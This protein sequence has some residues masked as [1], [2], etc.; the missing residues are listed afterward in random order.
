MSEESTVMLS[1]L[2]HSLFCP[3]QRVI[4]RVGETPPP[5]LTKGCRACSLFDQ[6]RPEDVGGIGSVQHWINNQLEAVES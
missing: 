1:A 6:C 5:I 3:W 4:I 2:Q